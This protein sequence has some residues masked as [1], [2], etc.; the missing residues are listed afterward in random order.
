MSISNIAIVFG[1]TLF[2]LPTGAPG[3]QQANGMADAAYQNKVG[4]D[5]PSSILVLWLTGL[6]TLFS[7]GYRDYSR[8]LY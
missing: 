1:P 4:F 3:A 2:G 5:T 6:I 7:L 8:A